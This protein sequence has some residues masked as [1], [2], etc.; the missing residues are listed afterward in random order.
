MDDKYDF[1]LNQIKY[2][3]GIYTLLKM[4]NKLEEIF[5]ESIF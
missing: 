4:D 5:M 1:N 2:I 3:L